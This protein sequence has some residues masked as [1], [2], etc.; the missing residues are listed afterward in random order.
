MSYVVGASTVG[1]YRGQ[2]HPG[3]IPVAVGSVSAM[4]SS[5]LMTALAQSKHAAPL[6]QT[7]TLAMAQ[8]GWMGFTGEVYALA[9]PP[10]DQ[11]EPGGLSPLYIA[12]GT[13]EDLG[14]GHYAIKD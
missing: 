3:G 6:P 7:S 2:D 9:D 12:L 13:W 14:D 11:R 5:H 8:V 4:I 10:Y 1:I